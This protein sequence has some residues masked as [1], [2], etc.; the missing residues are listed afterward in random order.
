MSNI[1]VIPLKKPRTLMADPQPSNS[2]EASL[3]Q[4]FQ[5]KKRLNG[6]TD[7]KAT[8][9]RKKTRKNEAESA[10]LTQGQIGETAPVRYK[11][12]GGY[13]WSKANVDDDEMDDD[14]IAQAISTSNHQPNNHSVQFSHL[15]WHSVRLNEPGSIEAPSTSYEIK[16]EE[17][18]FDEDL[19]EKPSIDLDPAYAIPD[20]SMNG[21]LKEEELDEEVNGYIEAA[22]TQIKEE[23]PDYN[24]YNE[25][26]SDIKPELLDPSFVEVI[27]PRAANEPTEQ[28]RVEVKKEEADDEEMVEIKEEGEEDEYEATDDY[29]EEEPDREI[30]RGKKSSKE[31]AEA[32]LKKEKRWRIYAAL[33]EMP[34]KGRP[35]FNETT[36][37]KAKVLKKFGPK[38]KELFSLD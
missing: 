37:L 29:A 9:K 6:A 18:E 3:R 13:W 4:Q 8:R 7:S 10:P 21:V 12:K 31:D 20:A 2:L 38:A 11:R 30:A 14:L 15:S 22:Y 33:G 25:F 28:S 5:N 1:T 34:P 35:S 16:Q 32:R 36:I 26:Y 17:L 27:D 24:E 23:E 19:E